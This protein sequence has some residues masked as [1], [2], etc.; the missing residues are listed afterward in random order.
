MT[1]TKRPIVLDDAKNNGIE[2]FISEAPDAGLGVATGRLMRGQRAQISH[3]L[4]P[5]MLAKIDAL[6]QAKGMTRAGFINFAISE[7]IEKRLG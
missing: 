6:A 1:I 3:T 7:Q 4:P 5:S 2:R